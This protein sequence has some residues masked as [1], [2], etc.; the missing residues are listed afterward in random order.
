MEKSYIYTV[1]IS[2]GYG[3]KIKTHSQKAIACF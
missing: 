2:K 3:V 1:E